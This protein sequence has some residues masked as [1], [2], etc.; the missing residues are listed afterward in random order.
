MSQEIKYDKIGVGYNQTRK[1]DKFLTERLYFFLNPV[2]NGIYL[3]IGC[4]TGNYTIAL[5][6]KGIKFIA[7]D[8]STEML[9]KAKERSST[10]DWRFGTA[11]KTGLADQSVD[12]IIATLTIHHWNNLEKSFTE[13]S[14]VMKTGG[15]MVIFT[16][17]P[18]Q[19]KTYWLNW[20]FPKMIK[21]S[22]VPMPAFETLASLMK[23]T[24]IEVID[25]EK[26]FVKP[27]LEDQFLQCG[28]DSPELYLREEIRKGISSFASAKD[29]AEV[30][31]GLLDLKRDIESGKI[32]EIIKSFE[33]DEGDY[34]FVVGEKK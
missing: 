5:N 24:G 23:K 17:T 32:K 4:G 12:G 31:Q 26:Y 9:T 21:D 30:Q 22:A 33:S 25:T 18:A 27:N 29:Q 14:R 19:M 28:K 11:E 34:L 6:K 20:Y 3:D 10:I 16:S 7:I 2:N 8:P 1:A 13:L 15:R